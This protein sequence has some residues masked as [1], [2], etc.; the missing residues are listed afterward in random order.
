MKTFSTSE[1]KRKFGRVADQALRG[2]LVIIVRKSKL[3]RLQEF[4]PLE[5]VPVRPSGYF[6]NAYTRAEARKSNRLAAKSP[7]HPV[8]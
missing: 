1:A 2:E 7:Q 8:L 5:A 6:K 4:H 3:L